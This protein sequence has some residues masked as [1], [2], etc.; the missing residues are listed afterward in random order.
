RNEIENVGGDR[1]KQIPALIAVE[2]AHAER[3]RSASQ[4]LGEALEQLGLAEEGHD[5]PRFSALRAR[6]PAIE[7]ELRAGTAR[8][9]TEREA[10]LLD[11][12][13]TRQQLTSLREELDGLN[14]RKENIPEWCVQLRHSVCHELGLSIRELPFAAELMQVQGNSREWEASIE[15]VLN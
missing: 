9:S 13:G 12:A 8:W 10:R 4:R 1:L 2:Q 11:R 3:K 14:R 6:M 15:K 5:E 7:A